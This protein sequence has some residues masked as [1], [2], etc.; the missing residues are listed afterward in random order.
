MEMII[1]PDDRRDALRQVAFNVNHIEV[2]VSGEECHPAEILDVSRTGLRLRA[3]HCFRCGSIVTLQ[4]PAD[5]D[6]HSCRAQIMRQAVV[7]NEGPAW[8]DY[9]LRFLD[10]ESDERHDWFLK[11][12]RREA[13]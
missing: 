6:L 11:L 12:R 1:A 13:A 7:E 9:G 4:P 10:M 5:S 8:F 3:D 2:V